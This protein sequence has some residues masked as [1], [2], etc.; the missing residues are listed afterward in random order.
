MLVKTYILA[1]SY[2]LVVALLVIHLSKRTKAPWY[3]E[4]DGY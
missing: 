3:L 1:K 4:F 2:V